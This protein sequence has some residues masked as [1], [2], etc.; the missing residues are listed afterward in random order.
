MNHHNFAELY[1]QV[2]IL[3]V[4]EINDSISDIQRKTSLSFVTSQKAINNL[5]KN[6][7]IKTQKKN[8]KVGKSR[9]CIGFS[10]AHRS[11]CK[12]L[13]MIL[14]H[15]DQYLENNIIIEPDI[16]TALD[17][18]QKVKIERILDNKQSTLF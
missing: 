6:Q 18:L 1:T 15:L 8:N 10:D 9:E 11:F 16:K 14:D 7:L 17:K 5:E 12:Q 13:I 3:S 2:K 4:L